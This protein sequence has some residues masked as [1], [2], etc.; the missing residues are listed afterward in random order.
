M[1][2]LR[3]DSEVYI[4]RTYVSYTVVYSVNPETDFQQKHLRMY[5]VGPN[6]T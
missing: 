3:T 6:R 4:S 2:V 5:T 1:S